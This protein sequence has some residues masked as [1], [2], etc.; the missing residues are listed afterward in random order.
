MSTPEIYIALPV[1]NEYENL[2]R[3]FY[4]LENQ[5]LTFKKLVVCVNN[6]DHWWDDDVKKVLCENNLKSIAFL[7]EYRGF[8]IKLIDR[9]SPGKGW[10]GKKGGIGWARKTI[11]DVICAEANDQDVIVSMDADT[12]YPADYLAAI[13][14]TLQARPGVDGISLPYYHQLAGDETDRLIL[15]Y[16]IYMRNYL[17]NMLH[18]GNPYAFTALGSAMSFTTGA[19]KR[20]GGLS[21]VKSGEDFYFLQKLVKNGNI[22]LWADTLAYPS[23]R[24]SDRVGFGTGPAL[25]KGKNRDW[26][27]Y[28]IYS[29]KAFEKI[30]MTFDLFEEL[31]NSDIQTP[32]ST[33]LEGIFGIE[34]LW[35]PLRLN[36]RDRSNFVRAC[37]NKVDGL[38]ILQFLR[39]ERG[40]DSEKDEQ[41]L[42]DNLIMFFPETK[43]KK[44][45]ERFRD[46]SFD[47]SPVEELNE[48]RNILFTKEHL[49]R[50]TAFSKE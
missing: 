29:W 2:E 18:I 20:I 11:V 40:L 33:F 1:L 31:R 36:Y 30:G 41:L 35:K 8:E 10:A 16:E 6:Y 23:P 25:I 32:M 34:N 7:R 46:L 28:P 26:T 27:S 43:V 19:C 12:E 22:T 48:L 50:Q 47:D 37:R 4:C 24:L 49:L 3:L 14:N 38:R 5:N 21:P 9:S 39:H 17:L 42:L 44:Y 45:R 13:R 15:R